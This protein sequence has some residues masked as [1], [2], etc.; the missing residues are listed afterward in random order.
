MALVKATI[1]TTVLAKM[2]AVYGAPEDATKADEFA[3]IMSEVLYDV[4]KNQ[5]QVAMAGGGADTNGDSLL[6]NEGTVI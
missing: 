6:V 3:E 5:V 2:Q 4:L 1:K